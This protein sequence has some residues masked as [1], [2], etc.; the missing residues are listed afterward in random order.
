MYIFILVNYHWT[1]K[2]YMSMLQPKIKLSSKSQTSKLPSVFPTTITPALNGLNPP[3]VIWA[4]FITI[5][6]NKGRITL[7]FQ[8]QKLKSC[9]VKIT[10]SK[11]G[12]R[13]NPDVDLKDL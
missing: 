3:Q 1:L 8:T 9:K 2:K 7:C 4:F 5:L 11:N 12:D 10:S 13:S 6:S